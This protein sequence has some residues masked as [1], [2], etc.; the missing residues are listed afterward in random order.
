[1]PTNKKSLTFHMQEDDLHKM[2]Y[3]RKYETRALSNL[4]EHM[5]R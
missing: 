2:R 4:P 1:M 3:F 5:C